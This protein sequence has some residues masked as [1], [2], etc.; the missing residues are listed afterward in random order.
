MISF[1]RE[2]LMNPN[3]LN[4]TNAF[5][6]AVNV[7]GASSHTHL[8]IYEARTD[9]IFLYIMLTNQNIFIWKLTHCVHCINLRISCEP[10]L[11]E[12]L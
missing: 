4:V 12:I 7:L 1:L 9:F 8:H 5:I 10:R 11:G 2:T 3:D 6:S